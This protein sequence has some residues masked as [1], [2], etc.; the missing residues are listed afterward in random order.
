MGPIDSEAET[1]AYLAVPVVF[2]GICL[3]GSIIFNLSSFVKLHQHRDG[4]RYA[5]PWLK[6]SGVLITMFVPSSYTRPCPGKP[7]DCFCFSS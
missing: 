3:L 4:A 5:V 1:I 7:T 2:L 6:A